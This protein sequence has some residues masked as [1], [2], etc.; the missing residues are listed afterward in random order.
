[1]GIKKYPQ[2]SFKTESVRDW[3]IKYQKNSESSEEVEFFTVIR[4]G[5]PSIVSDRWWVIIH[6]LRVSGGVI[7]RKTVITTGN[8]NWSQNALKNWLK[9]VKVWPLPQNDPEES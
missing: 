4:Q 9:T 3:K 6:I 5:H 8:D 1:M 7:R 2:F